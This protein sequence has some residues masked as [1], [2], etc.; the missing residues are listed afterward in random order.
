MLPHGVCKINYIPLTLSTAYLQGFPG[1]AYLQ[2]SGYEPCL[3]NFTA[4]V[5]I[6]GFF[7]GAIFLGVS[8]LGML[9]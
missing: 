6:K 5:P 2:N 3:Q 4:A 8:F 7:T 9:P 1:V